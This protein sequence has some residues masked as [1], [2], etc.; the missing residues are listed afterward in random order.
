[1]QLGPQLAGASGPGHTQLPSPSLAEP[2]AGHSGR[3][4][5][6]KCPALDCG[7]GE[8]GR[9]RCRP[10]GACSRDAQ[11]RREA[12][13]LGLFCQTHLLHPPTSG[14]RQERPA[15]GPTHPELCGTGPANAGSGLRCS[16]KPIATDGLSAPA[17][18]A[19]D[20]AT[21][22]L[23]PPG[24]LVGARHKGSPALSRLTGPSAAGS[25]RPPAGH[26]D[27]PPAPHLPG[28]RAAAAHT[29][30]QPAAARPF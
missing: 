28:A 7:K 15:A 10:N 3:L 30:G 17:D 26:V 4:S 2:Q 24:E 29:L 27:A 11:A 6:P 25:G 20:R 18:S 14:A 5:L 9:G 19:P 23:C 21:H 22:P 1:M 12:Q 13:H 16:S 8:R